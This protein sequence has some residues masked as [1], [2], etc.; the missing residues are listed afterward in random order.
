MNNENQ[1]KWIPGRGPSREALERMREHFPKP[2]ETMGEAW[3][4]TND[5]TMFPELNSEETLRKIKPQ[6]L[7]YPILFEIVSGTSSFGHREEWDEWFRYLLP[8]LIERSHERCFFSVYVLQAN[9]SAF[10][11]IFWKGIEGEYDG[12]R[13]DVIATFS[14]LLMDERFWEKK[15]E[16]FSRP[17]FLTEYRDGADQWKLPW[18]TG[19]ASEN[20]SAMIFFNLKYLKAEEIA[21]WTGSIFA[22]DDIYWRGALLN[23]L[24]AAYDVLREPVIVPSMIEKAK[25]ELQWECSH[26]MGS[27]Q[28]DEEALEYY[29]DNRLFIPSENPRVFLAEVKKH[30]NEDRLIEWASDFSTSKLIEESTWGIPDKLLEKLSKTS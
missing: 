20:L 13:E 11:N 5:R 18:D 3:F 8:Y 29:N 9:V 21:E 10:I 24:A 4:N 23:W 1:H 7:S 28:G 22:I 30:L 6:D 25:P 12:F 2:K 17:A 14:H 27:R 19:T 26:A 16:K 15:G